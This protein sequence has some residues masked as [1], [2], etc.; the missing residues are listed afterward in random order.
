MTIRRLFDFL[1]RI[2]IPLLLK[3]VILFIIV[4]WGTFTLMNVLPEKQIAHVEHTIDKSKGEEDSYLIWLGNVLKGDFGYSDYFKGFRIQSKL[5]GYF[6]TTITLCVITLV[7]SGIIGVLIGILV[8]QGRSEFLHHS[9]NKSYKVISSSL[10]YIIYFLSSF[11]AYIL[12]Y[13]IFFASQSQLNLFYPIISLVLGSSLTMD[14]LRTTSVSFQE[15]LNKPYIINALAL[16]FGTNG[17]LPSPRQVSNH[18]FRN[19]LVVILPVISSRLPMIISNAIIVEI[20]F[21][22][23]G[24]SEPLLGGVINKDIHLVLAVVAVSVF[25]IQVSMLAI[26]FVSFALSP[27]KYRLE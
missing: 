10:L 16:G 20:V 11:P 14:I 15:E 1:H 18:A 23:P 27:F 8:A 3:T 17:L 19:A 6:I 12:A 22:L 4:T 5:F 13:I 2:I 7:I 25:F 21:E 24:L 9:T 26:E